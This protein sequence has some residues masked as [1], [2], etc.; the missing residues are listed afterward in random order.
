MLTTRVPWANLASLRFSGF[1]INPRAHNKRRAHFRKR[2]KVL[3]SFGLFLPLRKKRASLYGSHCHRRK[4][5]LLKLIFREQKPDASSQI[6][7]GEPPHSGNPA[8]EEGASIAFRR[9][10]RH[11]VGNKSRKRWEYSASWGP[12]K[13]SVVSECRRPSVNGIIRTSE[14]SY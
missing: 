4:R 12:M 13:V 7:P 10:N 14:C 8:N 2:S 6:F 3:L 5:V 1:H 9:C 11:R